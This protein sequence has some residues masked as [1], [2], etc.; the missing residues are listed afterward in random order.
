MLGWPM[1]LK[2][3]LTVLSMPITVTENLIY[4][5]LTVII[6][7]RMQITEASPD[8]EQEIRQNF[9]ILNNNKSHLYKVGVDYYLNDKNTISIFTNQNTFS[10]KPMVNSEILDLANPS[11]NESQYMDGESTNDSQQYNFNYKH[12][13]D[14]EGHN[15][16]L[17]VDYNTYE[18]LGDTNNIFYNSSRPN[19]TEDTDTDRDNTTI[20]LDYV[21]PL[22]ETSKLELG[23]EARLF[24]TRIFYESNARET[25]E[26]GDYIPTTTRFDYSRDIYSAYATYGNKID[27]WS[28]QV[29]V[30]AE[31]VGVDSEAFKKDLASSETI[32][33]PFENDYFELYPSAFI[34]YAASDKNSYQF[35]YSRRIDRPGIGQVNPLPEWSTSLISQFGN[36]ELRPQFTNSIETNYTRQFEKGSI[37]AGVFYRIIEDEIQ[38][39]ILI[40][41]TDINR[42]IMTNMNFDNSSSY[43]VEVSSNYRPTKWW[44]VNASFDLFSQTQKSVAE[45]FDTNQNIVLNTVEVDNVAWSA[46]AFNNFRVSKSLSFSAFGMYRAKNKNIQFEMHDMLMV[47]LGM[48]Y[49][50]LEDNR[51]SF[52]LSYNDIFNTMY[53]QFESQRPYAQYGQFNWE[54]QQISARLS[55]RFGGGKYRAKSRKQRDNDVKEGGGMF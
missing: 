29:G 55:Y 6:L 33:I 21:N 7:L 36:Q 42:L 2:L 51:A 32:F 43:G 37:T 53:A 41:R 40:D 52:S 15:I 47:N 54:S 4:M 20:N 3:N 22:S 10:G 45:S 1:I 31:T 25:N 27:K 46:R 35:S 28:Y 30:R 11:L 12:D 23:L 39:A 34:T 13:F 16:E 5:V 24:D 49:S 18:G 26:F 50:F 19:F 14:E 9:D 8:L 38:Q 17:E 48:R 44:S